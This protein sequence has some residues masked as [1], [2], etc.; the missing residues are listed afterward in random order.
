MGEFEFVVSDG[1]GRTQVRVFPGIRF[2]IGA[3]QECQLRF[4]GVGLL[5]EH[6]EVSTDNRGQFWVRDL[7]GRN[8]VWVNGEAS[9]RALIPAGTL[10]RM[11]G[12]DLVVRHR[13]AEA[14]EARPA[15]TGSRP[16]VGA[17]ETVRRPTPF[18]S[19]EPSRAP[20]PPRAPEPLEEEA[21]PNDSTLRGTLLQSG[22]IIDDR[23]R[24]VGKLAAG[25]MG[26][27]YRAEHVELGKSMAIKVMLPDL[28]RDPEFVARFKREAI[29]ASR[30][31]Q[32][33]IVD[34]SDFGRT[35]DGRFYFVM[36]YLDGLTLASAVHRGG[37]MVVERVVSVTLQVARALTAAHALGIVHRDLKPE[38]IMLLQRPGQADFVKVLDFGVAKVAAGHGQ[39]GH[40]AVGMVV[41]TPQYM[42]PE[43]AKAIPVDARSDIYSLGLIV[44]ELI[45]GRPT[46][47]GE[48]PS[49]LMVK[50]VTET[51][52]PLDPGPLE[53][54]PGELEELVFQMLEKNPAARPQSMEDVVQR[55]DALYA[56][57][58]SGAPLRRRAAA[59]ATP[60]SSGVVVRVT[61]SQRSVTSSGTRNTPGRRRKASS[62]EREAAPEI[63]AT[64]ALRSKWPL[65]AGLAALVLVSGAGA[66]FLFA[67]PEETAEVEAPPPQ[68]VEMS[69]PVDQEIAP[70]PTKPPVEVP[71]PVV[72]KVTTVTLHVKTSP[73][74]AVAYDENHARLG[75]SPFD[76]TRDLDSVLNLRFVLKGYKEHEEKIRFVSE[77]VFTVDL[78]REPVVKHRPP[79]PRPDISGNPYDTD[80]GNDLKPLPE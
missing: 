80:H 68:H 59:M 45:T 32:Q 26:E 22:T 38:N 75:Q 34:I 15:G 27:V 64:P 50:H 20:E 17:D 73:P 13:R 30:I 16:H 57:L 49:I 29:A 51:P 44:Y 40:T 11:G 1:S 77:Q 19:I 47:S 70:A 21:T 67:G 53:E 39:G 5:D 56:K 4:E 12:L 54:V 78:E 43:Q 25:G 7:T 36:E 79:T 8:L 28:S 69:P 61:G 76:L 65:V 35:K 9:R 46:F 52:P 58:K 48:T 63:D 31:G 74:G 66:Y 62:I 71:P 24:V 14:E 33:N 60:K 37:A 41:G 23:Y 42:S 18:D 3:D 2:V 10:I 6:A 72:P 55:L